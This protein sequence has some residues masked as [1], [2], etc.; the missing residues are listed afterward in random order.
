MEGGTATFRDFLEEWVESHDLLDTMRSEEKDAQVF[1]S[2]YTEPCMD[3]DCRQVEWLKTLDPEYMRVRQD[4]YKNIFGYAQLQSYPPVVFDPEEIYRTINNV[5]SWLFENAYRTSSLRSILHVQALIDDFQVDMAKIMKVYTKPMLIAKCGGMVLRGSL[6]L[7]VILNSMLCQIPGLR[8]DQGTDLTVKGDVE[9]PPMS[10]L[11]KDLKAEWSI[12]YLERQ[13][14]SQLRMPKIFL[15]KTKAADRATGRHG[16]AGIHNAVTYA[17][18]TSQQR[19][20]N[21]CFSH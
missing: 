12:E 16:N 4:C 8:R 15:G 9:V 5:S 3:E 20:R 10:S 14:D 1:G 11:T 2:S 6:S 18:E 19:M 7:G 13:R 21:A 17:S